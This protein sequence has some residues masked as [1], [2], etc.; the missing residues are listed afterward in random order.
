MPK[1]WS[2][3]IAAHRDAVREATLD[4]AAA[5][6]AE[7]GLT[8]VTMSQIAKDTGIGRATLYKYF[9]DVESILRAWHERQVDEHL[10]ELRE[11][12]DRTDG[13]MERLEAVLTAYAATVSHRRGHDP[14]LSALLHGGEHVVAA[15]EHLRTFVQD[16]VSDAATAGAVRQDMSAAELATYSLHAL[17]AAATLNSRAAIQRLVR[18][19]LSGLQ[20]N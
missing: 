4:A 11:I 18:I 5:L 12:R 15:H 16:L 19:T 1:I 17:S 3:T 9:P 6:V 2:E 13:A 7:R 10:E 14:S 20:P 8:G